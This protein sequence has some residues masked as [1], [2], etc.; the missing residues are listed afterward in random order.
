MALG[1]APTT[2]PGAGKVL[3]LPFAQMSAGPEQAWLGQAIRQGVL[4]D[5]MPYA[6][7]R[8]EALH[9]RAAD[10]KAAIDAAR[11]AGAVYVVTGTVVSV[12]PA[13]RFDGRVLEVE[14]GNAVAPLKA[15]GPE[16]DLNALETALADQLGR[17][18]GL[19]MPPAA[20]L[21]AVGQGNSWGTSDYLT[22]NPYLPGGGDAGAAGGSDFAP[23]G[24]GGYPYFGPFFVTPG[25]RHH[26]G[27]G[28]GF[29]SFDDTPFGSLG[30]P[31]IAGGG[32]NAALDGGM[33][34]GLFIPTS[35]AES[36]AFNRFGGLGT[37]DIS[38]PARP[39][40]SARHASG[41]HAAGPRHK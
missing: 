35:R 13:V 9:E 28:A 14:S 21:P 11:R 24:Y 18:I 2:Q 3:V 5:L 12:G 41:G 29:G 34:Y 10:D 15:T 23:Y 16:D 20:P 1:A 39:G 36:R 27:R 6:P 17:A 40:G 25:A 19:A 33:P 37:V 30:V 8:V 4:S 7:G 26:H 31:S 32:G 38:R 22:D